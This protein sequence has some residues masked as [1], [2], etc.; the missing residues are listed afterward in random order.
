MTGPAGRARRFFRDLLELRQ[1]IWSGGAF[2]VS[3]TVHG[4]HAYV[5]DALDGGSLYGYRV[6]RTVA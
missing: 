4:N 1:V 5:L 3:V 6:R 2:P